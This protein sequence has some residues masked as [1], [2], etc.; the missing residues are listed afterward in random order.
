M[1]KLS[2]K[3]AKGVMRIITFSL[4]FYCPVCGLAPFWGIVGVRLPVSNCLSA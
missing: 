3:T 1:W 4:P 2:K